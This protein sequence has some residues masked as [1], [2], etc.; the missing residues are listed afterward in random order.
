MVLGFGDWLALPYEQKY[1]VA[2]QWVATQQA[3]G[4]G[5]DGDEQSLLT[6]DA[7]LALWAL[8]QQLEHGD[9]AGEKPSFW[10][11]TA[12]AKW[13]AYDSLRGTSSLDA[14]RKFI[15][16]LDEDLGPRWPLEHA[17][18]LVAAAVAPPPAD[19]APAEPPQPA[20]PS[21][22]KVAPASEVAPGTPAVAAAAVVASGAGLWRVL[23]AGSDGPRPPPR[24]HHTTTLVGRRLLLMG[25]TGTHGVNHK[26]IHGWA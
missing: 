9:N 17:S 10:E 16:I 22:P 18:A 20:A 1:A 23:A 5:G 12:S 7:K 8:G 19:A 26:L 6:E 25:G 14:M 15:S 4:Y 11:V 3:D 24:C 2:A 21:P 13:S